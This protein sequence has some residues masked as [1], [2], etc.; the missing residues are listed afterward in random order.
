[1]STTFQCAVFTSVLL[2]KTRADKTMKQIYIRYPIDKG[3]C[4]GFENNKTVRMMYVFPITK[5]FQK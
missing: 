3:T 1:M 5:L 4:Q 2:P